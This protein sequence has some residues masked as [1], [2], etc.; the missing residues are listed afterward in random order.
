MRSASLRPG[1]AGGEA[2]DAAPALAADVDARSGRRRCRCGCR[3]RCSSSAARPSPPKAPTPR[4]RQRGRRRRRPQ[5]GS[6]VEDAIDDALLLLVALLQHR[7]ARFLLVDRRHRAPAPLA[8]V[9]ADR[10]L[11]ADDL[12][13]GAQRLEAALA[14][15]ELGRRRVLADGDARARRVEQAH[16]LVGQ[17]AAGDVAVRQPHGRGDRL[18][19]QGDA[20]VLLEDRGDAAQHQHRLLLARLVDHDDLEAPRQRRVLL[21]VLLV[22]G[23][24]R[25]ADRAQ[26]AARQR[27]LEQVGRVAGAGRAAGADQ[28]V[29][30]VDEQDDRLRRRLHLVDHRA[31]PILE[32]ALH[33]RAGLQEADVEHVE[34]DVLQLRR[35]VAVREPEREAFD[36]RGLADAGL[37]GQD[38]IV[39]AP[40]H[41]DVDDLA[42]LLVAA[43]D[44]IDLAVA[45]ALGEVD[46]EALERLLLAHRRRRNGAARFARLAGVAAAVAGAL[47]LLGRAREQLGEVVGQVLDLDAVELLRDRQQRALQPRRLQHA[48]DQ[49]AGAHLRVAEHQRAVDPA[50]LDRVL[51]PVGE[52]GHRAGAARQAIERG[53]EVA[54]QRPDVEAVVL[55]DPVQ[56]GVLRVEDLVEPVLELDVGVAAQ[57]AEH[58]GAFDRLV[59][60]RVELA[61]Q[62]GARDLKHG[63]LQCFGAAGTTCRGAGAGRSG[64]GR[65]A[66]RRGD[67]S[68]R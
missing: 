10:F 49:V 22:L 24:R 5:L 37:A 19:E 41:Q 38:R 48:D 12:A 27:R 63:E 13:L 68:R 54:R 6:N 62:G 2:A 1:S 47:P 65:A 40:P 53:G 42:D 31:Q 28:R 15:L 32:L 8:D 64:R 39:L 4:R 20:M 55:D 17:L 33:A 26:L 18:V 35:H 61:E 44:R 34:R 36:D 66:H 45:R 67:R 57:L 11:A 43:G 14:V 21:D 60:Q 9:D 16:R 23:P 56:V 3:C 7:Q 50:A 29:R 58:G 59:G 46:G 25:R 52:I 51:D 30:L